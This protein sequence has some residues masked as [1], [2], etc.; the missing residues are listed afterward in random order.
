MFQ[1]TASVILVILTA[2]EVIQT[3]LADSQ[4]K[5]YDKSEICKVGFYYKNIS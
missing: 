2:S 5:Y 3:S 1:R 4:H